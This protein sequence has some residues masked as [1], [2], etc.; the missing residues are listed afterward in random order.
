MGTFSV[1][2]HAYLGYFKDILTVL[3]VF[4]ALFM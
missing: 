3:A 2:K 4:R 1:H